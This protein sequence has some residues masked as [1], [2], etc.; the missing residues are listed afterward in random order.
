MVDGAFTGF[1]VPCNTP[2]L[3]FQPELQLGRIS[4][5]DYN[6]SE[7]DGIIMLV[8]STT[9]WCCASQGHLEGHLL[10]IL[11][12]CAGFGGLEFRFQLTTMVYQ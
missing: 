1:R 9:S 8:P 3:L 10:S 12:L 4:L 7:D 2:I 6:F 11:E 5:Y